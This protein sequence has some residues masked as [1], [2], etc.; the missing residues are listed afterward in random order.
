MSRSTVVGQMEGQDW[1]GF[2]SPAGLCD[3]QGQRCHEQ[4]PTCSCLHDTNADWPHHF[5][6]HWR[7]GI[8]VSLKITLLPSVMYEPSS[9]LNFHCPLY[10]SQAC[11]CS[12]EHTAPCEPRKHLKALWICS[13]SEQQELKTT[14][15]FP[16]CSSARSIYRIEG[17]HETDQY[18]C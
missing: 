13:F 16:A 15:N 9:K 18:T 2:P 12:H 11:I 10:F 6:P 8:S 4:L 1:Q 7:T 3:P 17:F 14:R 5:P